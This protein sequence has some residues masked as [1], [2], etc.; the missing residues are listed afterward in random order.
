MGEHGLGPDAMVTVMRRVKD[1]WGRKP[2]FAAGSCLLIG[3]LAFAVMAAPASARRVSHPPQLRLALPAPGHVTLEMVSA[4]VRRAARGLRRTGLLKPRLPRARSL[5]P[6][7]RILYL[8]RTFR[9]RTAV[10]S[11]L[12]LVAVNRAQPGSAPRSAALAQPAQLPPNLCFTSATQAPIIRAP[13]S[14]EAY[15]YLVYGPPEKPRLAYS[16]C[17]VSLPQAGLGGVLAV[18]PDLSSRPLAASGRRELMESVLLVDE[19]G[20]SAVDRALGDPKLDTGHYDD[21]H[22][23]GWNVKTKAQERAVFDDILKFIAHRNSL[24][25]LVPMLEQDTGADLN[26]DGTIGAPACTGNP[27]QSGSTICTTVGQPV[28]TGGA[29]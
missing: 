14:D 13:V 28:V 22:S 19:P 20:D 9:T 7:V 15:A 12:F 25:G 24:S 29:F 26:G 10:R 6:S 17:R 23:F 16:E 27:P 3:A 4:T 1:A 11:T 8:R 2:R 5:P 21:G 18:N